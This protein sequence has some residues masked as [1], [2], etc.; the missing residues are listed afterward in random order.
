MAAT[1]KRALHMEAALRNKPWTAETVEKAA[2]A[3]PLD[4]QPIKDHR[5][6]VWYRSVVA[7]NL[8]R[9]FFE[10]SAHD[11]APALPPRPVGTAVIGGRT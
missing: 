8:M 11:N 4:F 6:S 9:A 7:A 2:Q 5:G 1:P 3:L 10:E